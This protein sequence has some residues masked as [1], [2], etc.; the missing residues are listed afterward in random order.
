[1]SRPVTQEWLQM[2]KDALLAASQR[3]RVDDFKMHCKIA[4][5]TAGMS[6]FDRMQAAEALI[7]SSVIQ[8]IDGKLRIS[9][10][11]NA[12]WLFDLLEEGDD[13]SWTFFDNLKLDSSTLK[14]F[15][16]KLLKDLGDR[17][18]EFMIEVIKNSLDPSLHNRI[19]HVALTDDTL[20][21]DVAAPDPRDSQN[22]VLLEVKT[23]S[24]PKPKFRFY[25]SRN[26]Y[27]NGISKQNWWICCIRITGGEAQLEGMIQASELEDKVPKDS[28]S[29][30]SWQ[31][32]LFSVDLSTH[33]PH[34]FSDW[35]LSL[36][37]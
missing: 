33:K 28:S 12:S 34:H 13:E 16:N 15:D 37:T 31:S 23:S 26:E 8:I 36:N 22:V 29:E 14:K 7:T 17:G 21:F 3:K 6:Y 20:G 2:S 9:S 5:A 24:R 4:N 18:E 25:L 27:E 1:M 10:L 35:Y 32:T 30:A 19:I 11:E